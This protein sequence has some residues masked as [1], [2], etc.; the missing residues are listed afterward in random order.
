ML[1]QASAI[2]M[3]NNRSVEQRLLNKRVVTPNSRYKYYINGTMAP[4]SAA[5]S[6]SPYKY[7]MN[8]SVKAPAAPRRKK[9]SLPPPTAQ[10][11]T[12]TL[13]ALPTVRALS[14]KPAASLVSVVMV[15]ENNLATLRQSIYTILKQTHQNVEL[16][17]IDNN[18]S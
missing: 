10:K 1:S 9:P 8:G 13:Q 2:N 12:T 17:I 7:L 5:S 3:Q 18:S 4:T 11:S 14:I 15:S 16:V 6:T